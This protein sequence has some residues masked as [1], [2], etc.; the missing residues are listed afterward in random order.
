[1]C[2]ASC[3]PRQ[4]QGEE[5]KKKPDTKCDN[6]IVEC[7]N[8]PKPRLVRL[9]VIRNATQNNVTGAKNWA[10]IKKA[11][12]DVIV[13]ATTTPNNNK[14]EWQQITWSGDSGTAVS[15][16]PNQRKLS[17]TTSKKYHVEAEL[18]GV[19]DNVYVWVLWATVT[20]NTSGTTPPNAVQF[21][22]LF[23]GTENL[24]AI[25][26]D[27]GRQ[28]RGK[29]APVHRPRR[30]ASSVRVELVAARAAALEARPQQVHE[31][32]GVAQLRRGHP[33]E[34]AVPQDLAP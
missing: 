22:P 26:Y 20:I 13:E 4:L 33:I 15:G 21:G 14:E 8:K 29:V 7:P 25:S 18:G 30:E 12:D 19:K 31:A 17:R 32:L 9:T 10:A 16:K 5:A 11:T 28:A 3:S 2:I 34:V 23:D 24:G 27:S 6:K 1:M